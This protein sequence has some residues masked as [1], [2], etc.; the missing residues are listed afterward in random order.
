M[1]H[2][3]EDVLSVSAGKT[4]QS[5]FFFFFLS[6]VIYHSPEIKRFN[7]ALFLVLGCCFSRIE[8]NHISTR[9]VCV[10]ILSFVADAKI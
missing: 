3:P 10:F 8:I 6:C 2:V 4:P 5:S 9:N 1:R 7:P